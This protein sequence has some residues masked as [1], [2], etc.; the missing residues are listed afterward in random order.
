MLHELLC[1][2]AECHT[3][4]VDQLNFLAVDT[5]GLFPLPHPLFVVAGGKYKEGTGDMWAIKEEIPDNWPPMLVNMTPF[6][7]P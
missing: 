5:A 6:T 2:L 4:G 7:S 3:E 1:T